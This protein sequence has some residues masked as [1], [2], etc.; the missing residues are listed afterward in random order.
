[1]SWKYHA[2]GDIDKT[3]DFSSEVKEMHRIIDAT[4]SATMMQCM[5]LIRLLAEPLQDLEA[6]SRASPYA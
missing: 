5:K 1:M 6:R 3:S 2:E 4:V